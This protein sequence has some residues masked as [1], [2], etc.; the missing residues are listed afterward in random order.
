MPCVWG[1]ALYLKAIPGGQ[2]THETIEAQKIAVLRRGGRRP[3]ASVYPAER[4][5]T[6]D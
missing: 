1:Q 2:A 4:R 6:R 5:A 3:Q